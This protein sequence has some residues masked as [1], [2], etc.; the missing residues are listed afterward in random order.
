MTFP[1]ISQIINGSGQNRCGPSC[2]A[3]ALA[4]YGRIEPTQE[5]MLQITREEHNIDGRGLTAYTD[6]R[7]AVLVSQQHGVD[8]EQIWSW[9]AV[10]AAL[11]A[12]EPVMLLL[13]NS[14]LRPRRYPEGASWNAHHFLLLTGYDTYNFFVNDPLVYPDLSPAVYTIPSV[15]AGVAGVGG[16]QAVVFHRPA[17]VPAETLQE[18]DVTDAERDA[19]NERIAALEADQVRCNSLK[20][21]FETYIRNAAYKQQTDRA[22]RKAKVTP[23]DYLIAK[24]G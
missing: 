8:A 4:G 10:Y 24:V 15:L 3:S 20:S 2:L 6:F 23:A 12:A 19:L 14:V 13:D 16:V 18:V 5:A 7:D 21:E 22:A 17:D 9:E 11:D 1:M